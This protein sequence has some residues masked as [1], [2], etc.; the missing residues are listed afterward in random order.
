MIQSDLKRA[1]V[2]MLERRGAKLSIAST[3]SKLPGFLPITRTPQNMTLCRI[4]A[5][6]YGT[7]SLLPRVEVKPSCVMQ[8]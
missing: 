6:K 5:N 2:V 4:C 8:H 7:L 3:V 1:I